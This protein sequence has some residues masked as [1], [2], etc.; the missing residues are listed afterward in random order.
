MSQIEREIAS[1]T[2]MF[3]KKGECS[4]KEAFERAVKLYETQSEEKR[5]NSEEKRNKSEI[6]LLRERRNGI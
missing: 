5:N 1:L 2:D 3:M 6:D 4:E